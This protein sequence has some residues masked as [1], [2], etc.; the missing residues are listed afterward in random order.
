M[1]SRHQPGA[2]MSDL[3]NAEYF[4]HRAA[5]A[6]V[7]SATATDPRAAEA[8]LDMALRYDELAAEFQLRHSP[9][10]NRFPLGHQAPA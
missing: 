4:A 5:Q 9:P 2:L 6:R 1:C 7:L 8:H 10:D 3:T